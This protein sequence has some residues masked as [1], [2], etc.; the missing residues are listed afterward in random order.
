MQHVSPNTP[1]EWSDGRV[2]AFS[3]TL[4]IQKQDIEKVM[5][6]ASISF[7]DAASEAIRQGSNR[8]IKK[9]I[10]SANS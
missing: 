5:K 4:T 7:G 3:A 2:P 1:I 10:Y 8:Q 6:G 9:R